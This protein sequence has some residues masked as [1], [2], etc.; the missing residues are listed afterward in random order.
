MASKTAWRRRTAAAAA[1]PPS[2]SLPESAVAYGSGRRPLRDPFWSWAEAS[3]AAASFLKLLQV[4]RGGLSRLGPRRRRPH[5]R[6]RAPSSRGF[7]AAATVAACWASITRAPSGSAWR[8][9]PRPASARAAS[10]N[11]RASAQASSL[12]LSAGA[13]ALDGRRDGL[14]CPPPRGRLVT[15]RASRHQLTPSSAASS[16]GPH[17]LMLD[18][19]RPR[20]AQPR[21]RRA[22]LRLPRLSGGRAT[23]SA[24]V[25]SGRRR[26]PAPR[27]RRSKL[28]W[29]RGRRRR[30]NCRVIGRARGID[31]PAVLVLK[32]EQRGRVDSR[33]P[34]AVCAAALAVFISPCGAAADA[35]ACSKTMAP[36]RAA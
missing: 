9:A 20:A 34:G 6:S 10:A 25:L 13:G 32:L 7:A 5:F 29:G 8:A 18:S 21:P 31:W 27:R 11:R 15:T 30:S 14:R 24:A 17:R 16:C 36:I 22:P 4:S 28:F 26:P 3:S 19:T 23:R 1:R 12:F 2:D 33:C 35:R